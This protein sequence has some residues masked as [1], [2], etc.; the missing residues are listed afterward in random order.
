MREKKRTSRRIKNA[1]SFSL[2]NEREKQN[3]KKS[4]PWD[5][6]KVNNPCFV[7]YHLSEITNHCTLFLMIGQW[8]L[9]YDMLHNYEIITNQ[10]NNL[11]LTSLGK[12]PK[13]NQ[14]GILSRD[15][16]YLYIPPTQ[17]SREFSFWIPS[18]VCHALSLSASEVKPLVRAKGFYF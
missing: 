16:E 8:P 18:L 11:M 7:T 4:E 17:I 15:H 3:Q 9:S 5:Q 6:Q 12:A 14:S 10:S 2:P 13:I 1:N